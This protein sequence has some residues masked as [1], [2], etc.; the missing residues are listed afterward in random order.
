MCLL[1]LKHYTPDKHF[2]NDWNI[3]E[4]AVNTAEL[5]LLQNALINTKIAEKVI[6]LIA[7]DSN[8]N[9]KGKCIKILCALHMYENTYVQNSILSHLKGSKYS[10]QFLHI[11][12]KIIRWGGDL[13]ATQ[14][15]NSRDFKKHIT[16]NAESKQSI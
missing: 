10:V 12:V 1:L 15:K 16:F 8:L 3:E 13:I 6:E 4:R 9:I 7:T 14:S 2:Y 11:L 5:V